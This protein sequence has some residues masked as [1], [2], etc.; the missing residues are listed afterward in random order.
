M[1]RTKLSLVLILAL[2]FSLSSCWEDYS[3]N[4]N[5]IVATESRWASYFDEIQSSGPF[6]V[7]VIYGEEYSIEVTAEDNLLE[8]IVTDVDNDKLKIRTQTGHNLHYHHPMQ[9]QITMPRLNEARLS[10]SGKIRT[11][12][13]EVDHF[14]AHLSG[15]GEI[16]SEVFAREVGVR[17]SGSGKVILSGE[18]VEIDMG[19]SGSGKILSYDLLQQYCDVKISGSGDAYVNVERRLDV[20]ISGSGDVLFVNTPDI[21]SRISGSGKVIDDN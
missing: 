2:A 19:I 11:G 20:S 9:V 4:G 14:S 21:Q 3:I 1:K 7:D 8:Y 16:E 13:F 18:T 5:G 17:I 15:S 12:T 6:I 10:G